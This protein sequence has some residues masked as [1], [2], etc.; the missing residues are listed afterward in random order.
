MSSVNASARRQCVFI[1][2][3]CSNVLNF[4]NSAVYNRRNPPVRFNP[5]RF[6]L[7]T[8]DET[9]VAAGVVIALGIVFD[10]RRPVYGEKAGEPSCRNGDSGQ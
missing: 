4:N 5:P 8:I 7:W 9:L 3:C 10:R 1:T 6:I 2:S